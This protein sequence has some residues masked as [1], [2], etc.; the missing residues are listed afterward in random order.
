MET[1][2]LGVFQEVVED[3]P[4]LGGI[5]QHGVVA[6]LVAV[7]KCPV[8][9]IVLV[10]LQVH[11]AAEFADRVAVDRLHRIVVHL[12]PV[13]ADG[14]YDRAPAAELEVI[15]HRATGAVE[16]FHGVGEVGVDPAVLQLG[17]VDAQLPFVR[18][19]LE[20]GLDAPALVP[21]RRR[22]KKVLLRHRVARP[23]VHTARAED[24]PGDHHAIGA[25]RLGCGQQVIERAVAVFDAE[26]FI[27]IEDQHPVAVA[28]QR[29]HLCVVQRRRLRA[30]A[31]GN[32]IDAVIGEAQFLEPHQHQI[33]AIRTIV[34]IDE[35]I[36]EADGQV[37]GD[38]FQKEGP[39]VLHHRDG[40]DLAMRADALFQT[41]SS[42]FL[43]LRH[44]L[45]LAVRLSA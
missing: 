31:L 34:R 37:M 38:P 43:G 29:F 32:G 5:A 36:G 6:H 7:L 44:V 26:E 19:E 10:L 16:P 22:G 35:D 8:V 25:L 39:L 18:V 2:Q 21:H 42:G 41:D 30:Q 1:V 28:D 45:P 12:G 27:G 13:I 20:Q 24:A 15:L 33:G 14:A 9:R 11:V 4:P 17:A 23:V 40:G 3:P